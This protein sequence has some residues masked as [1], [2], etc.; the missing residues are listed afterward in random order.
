MYLPALSSGAHI[1]IVRLSAIGDVVQ[2]TTLAKNIKRLRPDCHI[3]WLV[4]PPAAQLLEENP[5]I[6]RLLVWDRH[7]FDEASAHG[8][9][10]SM[11]SLL[12]EARAL[13]HQYDYDIALDIQCLFLTGL[14]T[15]LSG[16]KRCIGIHE[17]HE[18]NHFFMTTVAPA[19]D[20][21]HKVRR[22]MTALLP[23]DF[24]WRDFRPGT[25]ITLREEEQQW[26]RDFLQE[27]GLSSGDASRPLL[28]VALRTTWEDKHPAPEVFAEAL[29]PLEE[30]VQIVFIGAK[31]D[32]PAIETCRK[33]LP[34]KTYSLAGKLTLREL[35]ALMGEATLLLCCDSGPLYIAE[36]VGLPTLSLW[37]PTHPTI[38]GPL[39]AGHHFLLTTNACAAC[40]K[41]KCRLGT[42]A[43]M[44]AI[45]PQRI[46]EALGE[47]LQTAAHES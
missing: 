40:C 12:R 6:D 42:N 47:C 29:A 33:L 16:A 14:L 15:R 41:T 44:K 34:Q 9:I 26:A 13:L 17:R 21:P 38:Y 27:Q 10:F 45:E 46:T 31:D 8:R 24:D 19:I 20:D 43:C 18:G 11:L 37:G 7:P 25:T 39:T 23:L 3:T 28:L 32:S 4:S 2:S 5:Y 1:L 36:A 35:A 22:Y 30:R